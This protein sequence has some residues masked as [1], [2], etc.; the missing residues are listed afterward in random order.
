MKG[1]RTILVGLG[2]AVAGA[3]LTYLMGVD[4]TQY[5]GPNVALMIAGAVQIV[6]RM[7]TTG[8]VGEK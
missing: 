6:M 1:Y 4:W 8:P 3:G 2:T 7:V 5:V